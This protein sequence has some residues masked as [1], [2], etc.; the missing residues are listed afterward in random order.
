VA[1]GLEALD[2]RP[3]HDHVGGVREVDPDPH[4]ARYL[5]CRVP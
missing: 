2:E 3:Q 1:L 4:R 5:A